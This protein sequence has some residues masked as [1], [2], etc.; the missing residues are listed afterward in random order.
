MIVKSGIDLAEKTIRYNSCPGRGGREV[1]KT[2]ILPRLDPSPPPSG[3]GQ[4]GG[5]LVDSIQTQSVPTS[6]PV[7]KGEGWDSIFEKNERERMCALQEQHFN[8]K[9]QTKAG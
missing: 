2:W 3:E 6:Q 1:G 9:R 5:K 4:G 8:I 7:H